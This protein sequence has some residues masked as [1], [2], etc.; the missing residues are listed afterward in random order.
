[1]NRRKY[2]ITTAIA[3]SSLLW[4]TVAAFVSHLMGAGLRVPMPSGRTQ[5]RAKVFVLERAGS[6]GA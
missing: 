3:L 6:R 1:M 4:V 5:M 2:F